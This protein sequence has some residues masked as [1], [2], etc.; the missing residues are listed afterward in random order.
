M[1]EEVPN[2]AIKVTQR[3]LVRDSYVLIVEVHFVD[4]QQLSI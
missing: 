1:V 3:Q 4:Y 2:Y